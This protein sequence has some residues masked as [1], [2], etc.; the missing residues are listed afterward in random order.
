VGLLACSKL[1]QILLLTLLQCKIC[2]LALLLLAVRS[3]LI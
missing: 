2:L 1:L 3:R